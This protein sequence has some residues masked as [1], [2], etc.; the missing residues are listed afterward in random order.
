MIFN[1]SSRITSEDIWEPEYLSIYLERNNN[2]R[3]YEKDGKGKKVFSWVFVTAA[4]LHTY[5]NSAVSNMLPPEGPMQPA[6]HLKILQ[7]YKI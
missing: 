6:K 7:F 3:A 5:S 2:S 1:I 4:F